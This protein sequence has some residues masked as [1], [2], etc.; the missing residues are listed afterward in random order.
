MSHQSGSFS[1]DVSAVKGVCP[2]G[3]TTGKRNIAENRVPV[4]SCEGA[5]I[6]GEIARRAA[7]MLG[8]EKG[9]ARGCHGE[10]LT[11]PYSAMTEWVKS[12]E[13]AVMIDGCF[14]KCHGRL[15]ENLIG[16]ER[17]AH[18][19]ALGIYEK[20]TDLFDIDAVPEPE[21]NETARQV[22]DA[23]LAQLNQ[24]GD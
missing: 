3:E 5:C 4:F 9:F 12:A 11:V 22:A 17:M 8:K 20:Y 15:I 1:L 14:L 16:T 23:I 24:T 21:L 10:T 2:V 6:R 7:N 18:F 13:M 19:D